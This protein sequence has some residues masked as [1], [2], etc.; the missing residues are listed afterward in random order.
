MEDPMRKVTMMR[1]LHRT[2]SWNRMAAPALALTAAAALL[3]GCGMFDRST[4]DEFQVVARAP[5]EMPPD[6]NLRPPSPGSPRPQELARDSRA[7]ATVFGAAGGTQ[8]LI[9]PR[10]SAYQSQGEVA[11]LV[12]A[13]ADQADPAI[14]EMVDRENPGVVVGERSFLDRLLFWQEGD[15]PAGTIHQGPTPTIERTGTT[16][17][18]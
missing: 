13:G 6:F 9:D 5:L 11:L 3:T 18:Q 12:Q 15:Q 7:T 16:A 14:R 10:T 4:P 17:G 8:G 2:R 1:P